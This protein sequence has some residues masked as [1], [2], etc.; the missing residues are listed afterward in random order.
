[1]LPSNRE[2]IQFLLQLLLV[3]LGKEGKT[4]ATSFV[5]DNKLTQSILQIL[6]NLAIK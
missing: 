6:I 5:L 1:M 4:K 2:V 3:S